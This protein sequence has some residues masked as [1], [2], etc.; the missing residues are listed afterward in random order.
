M[1]QERQPIQNRNHRVRTGATALGLVGASVLGTV[2]FLGGIKGGDGRTAE[3]SFSPSPSAS[4]MESATPKPSEAAGSPSPKPSESVKPSE[5]PEVKSLYNIIDDD[6]IPMGQSRELPANTVVVGDAKKINGEKWTDSDAFTGLVTI[7]NEPTVV[8]A[9]TSY[10]IDYLT[11]EN[12]EQAKY[13]AA[14]LQ[15]DLTEGG[16]E[17]GN[18]CKNG[19]DVLVFPGEKQGVQQSLDLSKYKSN[20]NQEAQPS[21]SPETGYNFDGMTKNE[22]IDLIL[23]L[24]ESKEVDIASPTGKALLEILIECGCT[25]YCNIPTETPAPSATPKPTEKPVVCPDARDVEI[26]YGGWKPE[27]APVKSFTGNRFIFQS[28]GVVDGKKRY[29]NDSNTGLLTIIDKSKASKHSFRFD[30]GGDLTIVPPCIPDSEFDALVA[31]ITREMDKANKGPVRVFT[32]N[33]SGVKSKN[34]DKV[35]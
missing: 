11:V 12:P 21:V 2:L 33:D 5:K 15:N 13:L 7:L 25:T 19:T 4:A 22:K 20:G 16:C 30:Y 10:K 32:I 3:A 27:D 14:Q 6:N 1:T 18:G 35:N 24:F 23:G 31:R 29:D 34:V 8:E 28:D 26:D 9:G 17:D